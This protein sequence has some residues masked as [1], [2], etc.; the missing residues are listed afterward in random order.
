MFWL[1]GHEACGI[2]ASE[3]SNLQARI[4]E[5][6]VLTTGLPRESLRYFLESLGLC[7]SPKLGSFQ[8]LFL[9]IPFPAYSVLTP[10]LHR[11]LMMWM[12]SLLLY[13]QEFLSLYFF[14]NFTYCFTYWANSIDHSSSSLIHSSVIS[15]TVEPIH[16]VYC[17]YY[18]I[19]HTFIWPLHSF[20]LSYFLAA[21]S[22]LQ[23]L[24]LLT[25]DPTISPALGGQSLNQWTARE[26]PTLS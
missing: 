8:P 24:N 10:C 25:R 9:R 26:V 6:E 2:L 4:L 19:F 13:S 18:H 22:S 15:T 20:F 11:I 17:S 23:D 5:D 1:S 12:L 21:L 14:F 3:G 16:H 7:L